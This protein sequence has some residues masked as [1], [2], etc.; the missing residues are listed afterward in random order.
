MQRILILPLAMLI[1]AVG[2]ACDSSSSSGFTQT[3]TVVGSGTI[4][5]EDRTVSG[6]DSVLFA[7][8]GS[9][10]IEMGA[11]ESLSITTDDNLLEYLQTDV[12]NGRLEIRTERGI[13][14]M[15]SD[16]IEYSLTAIDLNE[17][18]HTGVGEIEIDD[19]LMTPSLSLT[20]TGVGGLEATDLD[21]DELEIDH[22]GV[23]GFTLSGTAEMQ[24]ITLSGVG[25]FDGSDL[26][27]VDATVNFTGVGTIVVRVSGTLDVTILGDG[28]VQYIGDPALTI[29]ITGTGR[30]EQIPN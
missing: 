1:V 11:V 16:G 5:A 12:R 7:G 14:V 10:E 15:P 4:A 8:E 21:V 26:A 28:L 18:R 20:L 17:I 6:F 30:V 25:N 9:L 24:E 19:L 2:A 27:G 23:G 3:E 29:D 22:T 13:D